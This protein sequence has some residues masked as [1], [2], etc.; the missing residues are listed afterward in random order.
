LQF[1]YYLFL[2]KSKIVNHHS[3]FLFFYH[4]FIFLAPD[5]Y[6]SLIYASSWSAVGLYVLTPELKHWATDISSLQ[7]S[8]PTV[9]C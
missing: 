8:M 7:D 5:S 2:Q 9:N 6:R 3:I 4:R 1:A